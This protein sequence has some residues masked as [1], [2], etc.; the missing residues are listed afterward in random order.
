MSRKKLRRFFRHGLLPQLL[1]FDAVARLGSITRAAEE[2]HLAQPT[3]S[4]QMKKL[5]AALE[6]ALFELRGRQLCLTGAGCALRET[7]GELIALLG[8]TDER[9][10]PWREALLL[11]AL[12]CAANNPEPASG[13][14]SPE[15]KSRGTTTRP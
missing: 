6:V 11:D 2:L 10:A 14:E 7:C 15:W 5:A 1:V 4:L 13:E 3:V 8:R 12:G 9:L